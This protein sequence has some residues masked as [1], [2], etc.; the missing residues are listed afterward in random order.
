MLIRGDL[1]NKQVNA[2]D[3]QCQKRKSFRGKS[4]RKIVSAKRPGDVWFRNEVTV[5]ASPVS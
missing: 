5:K 3:L 2:K 1:D 4:A